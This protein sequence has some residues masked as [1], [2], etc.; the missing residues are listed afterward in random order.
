MGAGLDDLA[1]LEH[2]DLIGVADGGE[3]MRDDNRGAS[4][5]NP[6]PLR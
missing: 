3:A 6:L 2:E 5:G 1:V 4:S